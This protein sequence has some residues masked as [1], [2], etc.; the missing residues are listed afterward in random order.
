MAEEQ[1]YFV[2]AAAFHAD[3]T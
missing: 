2:P 3:E 1:S